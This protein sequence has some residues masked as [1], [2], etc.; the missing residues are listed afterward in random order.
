MFLA[1][2]FG[3][4]TSDRLEDA[5]ENRDSEPLEEQEAHDSLYSNPEYAEAYAEG[6][7]KGVEDPHEYAR[8]VINDEMSDDTPQ[9]SFD[10]V[11]DQTG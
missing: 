1:I 3:L 4:M 10:G 5:F 8:R 9:M 7:K 6:K 11:A 2:K